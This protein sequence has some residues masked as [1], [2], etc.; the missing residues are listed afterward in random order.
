MSAEI[1]RLPERPRQLRLTA[2]LERLDEISLE[3][4]RLVT[5]E[6]PPANLHDLLTMTEKLSE[7]LVE[8]GHLL[9]DE[10]DKRHLEGAFEALTGMIART[11]QVLHDR[12]T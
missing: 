7:R 9:L 8:L 3:I 4:E 5:R 1:I 6:Q 11:R 12:E 2:G 10:N